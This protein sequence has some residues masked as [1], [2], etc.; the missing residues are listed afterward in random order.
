M[1]WTF[2][3]FENR[4]VLNNKRETTV[5]KFRSSSFD[6]VNLQRGNGDLL[7]KIVKLWFGFHEGLEKTFFLWGMLVDNVEILFLVEGTEDESFVELAMNVEL[8]EVLFVY[9]PSVFIRH[10]VY[11]FW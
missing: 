11:V 9:V 6:L 1:R 10:V 7:G 4:S 3:Y 5:V 2:K 8:S